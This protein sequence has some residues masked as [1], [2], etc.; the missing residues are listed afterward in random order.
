ML[1]LIIYIVSVIFTYATSKFI[2]RKWAPL[3]EWTIHDRNALLFFSCIMPIFVVLLTLLMIL[4]FYCQDKF[5]FKPNNNPSK[6]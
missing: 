1:Y 6:W 3:V 5:N 2:V 4:V